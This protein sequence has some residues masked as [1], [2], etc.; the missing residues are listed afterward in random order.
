MPSGSKLLERLPHLIPPQ[1]LVTRRWLLSQGVTSHTADNWVKRGRLV[2]L[3]PGVYANPGSPLSW[4]SVVRSL[5][6]MGSDLV[7]G[8]I[9]SLELQGRSHFEPLAHEY[10]VNLYGRDSLPRWIN[11]VGLDA[12]FR[13]HGTTWLQADG[14]PAV[15][16]DSYGLRY[17]FAV[18][19]DEGAGL[20]RLRVSTVERAFF[21]VLSG[22]PK[23]TSFEHAEL[24]LD[25]LPDL[26][27]RRLNA[28]LD[29][30]RSVKVKRLFFWLARRQQHRW[31]KYVPEDNIDF[32]RGKR[33]LAQGGRLNKEYLITVP[34]DMSGDA[35]DFH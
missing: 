32:G 25:G 11:G 6:R 16:D 1:H 7:V 20:G 28:L 26:L 15:S 3:R 13:R 35:R 31:L 30:T 22:V 27:P 8:G 2:V 23:K 5:Q 14:S 34:K 24:L 33:H 9:T 18:F 21:E 17:P 12:R 4:D 10:H 19:L 29:R